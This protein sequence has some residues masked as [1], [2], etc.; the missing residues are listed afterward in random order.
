MPCCSLRVP[1]LLHGALFAWLLVIAAP[2][3]AQ[4]VQPLPDRS[5]WKASTSSTLNPSM[6]PDMA[7]DNDPASKWGGPFSPGHWWQLDLGRTATVNGVLIQWDSGFARHYLIQYSQDGQQ[8]QTALR[9][10]DGSG[11]TEYVLFPTVQARYLRLAAPERSADWGVSVFEFEPLQQALPRVQGVPAAQAEALWTDQAQPTALSA[12]TLELALPRSLSLAGL[13]VRWAQAPR[14]V[15]LE[16]RDAQGRWQRLAEQPDVQ[17]STSFL[18]GDAAH[19]V[20]ALRLRVQGK[21]S[22]QRLRLLGPKQLMTPLRRYEIAASQRNAALFPSSLRQQQVYWTA[23]G[24][25]AGQQKSVF[26]EY[27]NLEAYKGAPLVQPIWRDASGRS[28]AAFD[29]KL[30]HSLRESWMPMPA[31]EWQP[32]PDLSLRSEAFTIEQNG[33]PVTLLRHRLR[34]TGSAPVHGTLALV[35]RPMQISPPWQ[36]GGL[37]PIHAI[38]VEGDRV[39]VN[40]RVLLHSLTAPNAGGAAAFGT[41]GQ[42]EITAAVASGRLPT[43][44]QTDDADGL[45]AAA[46]QYG[47]DLQPGEQRDIVLA[48]ALGSTRIDAQA[49]SL[50]DSPALDRAALLGNS[51]DAGAAFDHL[52][53]DVAKQWQTRL[54][55]IGLSLP[56]ASLVDMLRA[57]AAYMLINQSG[58]AMQ[59][60]PRNYNRSFIRDGS[61][62]AAI[63]LRMG[64]NDSARD[65]LRWYAEHAVHANGLV[66]PILNDD[67]SVNTGFGS[68]L[69]HD[70]Q[71]Q[72]VWLVAEIARLD[73]GSRSVRDYQDKVKRALRFLQE[74][75]ERTLVPG[76]LADRE[77]PE[78]FHGLIA[79]SISHEGYPVPTHSYWDD[80]W[81]LKGWHDGAWLL[82]QWGDAEGAAWAR[83]QYAALRASVTASLRATMQWK[84]ID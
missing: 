59:P 41:H 35:T 43:Q 18:A 84:G 61:A 36:N 80:Y 46:L 24:I 22:L 77:A 31:V 66:S 47:V 55:K 81:A 38:A 73:G 25:P 52:A 79:P 74:L 63:L 17:G 69:E 64:M 72:F 48:F 34:N 11:G 39:R 10:R 8:W 33:A 4:A 58:H 70:S 15:S 76:Y 67:G 16:G 13:E 30:C 20:D 75:R 14:S 50:P 83:E 7:I 28:A 26:D 3:L 27:G 40:G 71:G 32:Q 9:M 62:T 82:A 68:D 2:V 57:Q 42:N 12:Q 56:D 49:K 23:V 37:S 5:Q 45:A 29:A 44:Q 21:A 54:G 60:G 19:D 65:Y 1:A 53:D 51:R 6:A 78:R